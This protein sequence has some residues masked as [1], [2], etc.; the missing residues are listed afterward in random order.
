MPSKWFIPDLIAPAGGA[1]VQQTVSIDFATT[2]D[3]LANFTEQAIGIANEW[4]ISAWV[5]HEVDDRGQYAIV[6]HRTGATGVAGLILLFRDGD[7]VWMQT[8]S[9]DGATANTR[10]WSG[11]ITGTGWFHMF[12]MK[13]SDSNEVEVWI[14][15]VSLGEPDTDV[16]NSFTMTDVDRRIR[17]GNHRNSGLGTNAVANVH[18]VALWNADVSAAIDDLYNDG[19]PGPVNLNADS[20]SYVFSENLAHWWRAGH[21]EEDIGKDYAAAGITPTIDVLEDALNITADDI[22]EDVPS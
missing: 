12:A 1:F 15:G 9:D 22:V 17:L 11:D 13:P 2:G 5:K 6:I 3:E 19:D 4:S 7:N 18:S 8:R 14:N 20:G 21:D 10:I 16:L